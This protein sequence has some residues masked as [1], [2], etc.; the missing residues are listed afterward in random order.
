VD[1]FTEATARRIVERAY[2]GKADRFGQPPIHHLAR[3]V[4]RV[5]PDCKVAAWLHDIVEDGCLTFEQVAREGIGADD[6]AALRLLTRVAE[7]TYM[8]YIHRIA[9][10]DGPA[11]AIARQVKLSDLHDNLTRKAPA[12]LL[13]MRAPG[14]RYPRALRVI[15]DAARARE[16]TF[17]PSR[18]ADVRQRGS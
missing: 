5:A 12:E 7:G 14:G 6:L 3:V 17:L 8:Q 11:G 16:E 18:A 9:A 1:D 10:A 15:E 2:C 13:G 4:A